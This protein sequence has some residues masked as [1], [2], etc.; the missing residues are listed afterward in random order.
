[1]LYH[2]RNAVLNGW[3]LLNACLITFPPS[4]AL[5]PYLEQFFAQHVGASE[6]EIALYATDGIHSL[7]RCFIKGERKELPGPMEIQALRDHSLIEIAVFLLDDTHIKVS[8]SAWTTC[9]E[10]SQTVSERLGIR[11]TQAFALFECSNLHEERVVESEERILDLYALWERIG[12]ERTG[13]GSHKKKK[14]RADK[15]GEQLETECTHRL[16]YK[17]YLWIDFDDELV[18]ESGMVY[19]QAVHN[20]VNGIY[21]GTLEKCIEL[22][23]YQLHCKHGVYQSDRTM[24]LE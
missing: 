1:M 13:K 23:S 9:G 14:N 20:V 22:A 12:I 21:V 15:K 17:V 7:Q 4:K 11:E 19:L 6:T 3:L 24:D 18:E 2:P 5:S 16:I 8:V 10:L